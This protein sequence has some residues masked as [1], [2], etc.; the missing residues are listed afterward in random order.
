MATA[1]QVTFLWHMHQPFYRDPLSG[2]YDLPWTYLHGVKDY[3]DMAAIVQEVDDARVVFNLVPSLLEQIRDYADGTAVDRFL[4][5]GE[6]D[7]ADM[8]ADQRLFLLDNFFSVNR[9]RMIDTH[10]RYLELR[11]LMGN[12]SHSSSVDRMR[13]V[14]DQDLLDLQVWFFLAWTGEAAKRRYPELAGMIAKGRNFTREDKRLLLDT[15]RNILREIIPLYRMLH[16]QGKVE[17]SVSPYFHP[18]LPLLCDSDIALAS[19][20]RTNP[21]GIRFRFPEDARAQVAGGIDYFREVFGFAPRGMWPSEGSVSDETLDI[22]SDCGLEWAAS[23][24]GI[25]AASLPEGLGAA[26]ERLYHPYSFTRDGKDI[27]LFFRDRQL[28][29]L[30]GFTYSRWQPGRAVDDFLQRLLSLRSDVP[31]ADHVS[32]ILDG[33][34]AWEYYPENG[35]GFLSSLYREIGKN[36]LLDFAKPSDG[37]IRELTRRSLSHV[38]PGSWINANFG[39]WVGHPEENLAWEHLHKARTAA[40]ASNPEVAVLMAATGMAVVT[41]AGEGP[42]LADSICRSLYAAEGSDWFWWYGDDHFS[43]HSDHFDLLFRNNLIN[44]YRLLGMNVP[45]ELFQAIKKVTPAGLVRKPST[46]ITPRLNGMV[47]DY[48]EWHGAGLYDLSRQSSAM[49]AGESLLNC[50]FYGYDRE[51]FYVRADGSSPFDKVLLPDDVLRL[52]LLLEREFILPLTPG[53]CEGELLVRQDNGWLG[54]GHACNWVVSRV[55]ELRVPLAAF[56]PQKGQ[57]FFAYLTLTRGQDEIGRWPTLVP[58][59]I[60]Y[61]GQELELENW[62]V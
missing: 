23:D 19:T 14:S 40:V 11:Y 18:I 42:S 56:S 62:L 6:M 33:E 55:C 8:S 52:H 1:L 41:D 27:T 15:H 60:C 39:I 59:P 20:P 29:D 2:V 37:R 4:S 28:S 45:G 21:P 7:P 51:F 3:F 5:H 46:L 49:H 24:E 10:P 26:K 35:Y 30:I 25:L 22:L 50:F 31:D 44:V 9:E 16:E 47:D 32:I 54:T 13:K 57:T 43:P 61:E 12:G 58:L 34:N 17:L 38:H 36:R 53:A 48:F